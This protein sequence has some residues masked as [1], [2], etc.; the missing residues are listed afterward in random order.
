MDICQISLLQI[1]FHIYTLHNLIFV[2]GLIWPCL[3]LV[4]PVGTDKPYNWHHVNVG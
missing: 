1:C 3:W 4:Q 2:C